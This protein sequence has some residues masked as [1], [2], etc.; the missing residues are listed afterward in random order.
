MT[1]HP[2]LDRSRFLQGQYAPVT[3]EITAFDLPVTGSLPP[4]L[5][6]RYLRNGPNPLGLEDP[7]HWFL[8]AGMVHRVRLR[9]GKAEWYR[10]R[11]VRSR[12]VA[13]SLGERWPAG[14][15]HADMDFAANTHVIA[16]AGRTLATVE[17]GPLPYELTPEL[18]T[19]G[20]CDFAGTLPGGYAAHTKLDRRTGDLHAVA[21]FWGW[22]HVQ[23]VVVGSDGTVS[24]TTDVPVTDGPMMHDFALTSRYVVL[25]DLPVTFSMEAA[26]AGSSLPY[27]WNPSH[28]ARVGL[29]PRTGASR[30]VCW[31]EVDPCWV[32]HTLNAYDD[33]DRVVVDTCRYEGTYDMA[34]LAEQGPLTLERWTIDLAAG[35]VTQQRLDDHPQEFPRVDE[36]V[37]SLPHRYGYSALVGEVSR[38]TVRPNGDF[39]DDAFA[40]ALL[41]HDLSTG[42]VEVHRFERDAAAGEAVFAP[43]SPGAAEDDGYVMAFVHDPDRGAADLVVLAAQDFTGEP[44]AAVHL[45]A[46]VPL[47][48]HGS[49]IA[50]Q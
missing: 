25:F 15:V 33:G 27:T 42:A 11:W 46:R 19:V 36:R 23:H 16:H 5:D 37:V 3:E 4:E 30:E 12:Q 8:G 14:P 18:E 35:K 50:D 1:E 49:W 24:S 10:N 38:D 32:F 26:S 39:G 45:P 6:G 34:V 44:V 21:Y 7:G 28:Q 17:A 40:N 47:G 41:K 48:F 31:F 20:P 22:D 29:L 13:E 9:D 43:S 2:T